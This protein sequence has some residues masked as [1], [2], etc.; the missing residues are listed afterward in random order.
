MACAAG[1]VMA[2]VAGAMASMPRRADVEALIAR[3]AL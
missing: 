2:G 1:A 3:V